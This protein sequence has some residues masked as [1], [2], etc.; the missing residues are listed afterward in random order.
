L[1]VLD[2]SLDRRG[3]L[4]QVRRM[5]S[6]SD[7][8]RAAP[9]LAQQV[10]ERLDAHTHKTIATLRRDGSPRISG[11]E[12]NLADG[13]L[14]IGSMWQA[15]KAH[16]LQRDPRFAL[17]SGSDEPDAWQGDAK[18]AGAAEEITDPERVRAINGPKAPPGPSHLF[19][20]DLREVSVVRLTE[21]RSAL[22]I[23][24]WTPDGGV[25]SRR[26]D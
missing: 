20:L 10:R 3:R 13:E 16:D 14:W 2:V 17:H 7:F 6:W 24:L 9:A 1:I 11:T 22:V 18:L 4:R 5:P 12:T 15:R 8:E 21:D 25:R 26:R 23:D 19:R